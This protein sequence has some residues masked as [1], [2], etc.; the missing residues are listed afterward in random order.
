MPEGAI[1]VGRPSR[2]GNP[3]SELQIGAAYPSVPAEGVH[4]LAVRQFESLARGGKPIT[5][6]ERIFGG[7]G[8]RELV[9]YTYPSVAEI[10]AELAGHDLAC[11]CD[12]DEMCHADVLLEL[13]REVS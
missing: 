5:F 7:N 2:W 12:L 8:E 11:W 4:V 1:Y 13:C 3:F 6:N 10:V 9:T